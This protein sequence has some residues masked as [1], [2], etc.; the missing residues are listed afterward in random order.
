MRLGGSLQFLR[1]DTD[2][3]PASASGPVAVR[4]PAT[5][6]VASAE[7]AVKEFL[8]AAEYSRWLVKAESSNPSVFPESSTTSERAYVLASYRVNPWL[9]AGSYYSRLVPDVDRRIFPAGVQHD[10]ALTLRFDVNRYWLI[11]AEGHYLRGTAG[12]SSSL[13]GNQLLSALT[14][15]WAL[16]A[17]KTTAYF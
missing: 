12:L 5:L 8:F 13:N 2:L 1:L 6:W 3:L 16:F 17:V 15:N 11:K 10:F 7:Y 14:P 4:I 9:Q